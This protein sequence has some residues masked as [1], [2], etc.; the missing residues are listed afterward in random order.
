MRSNTNILPLAAAALLAPLAALAD[1][2][3]V[4]DA[5]VREGPPSVRVLAGY[6]QVHNRTDAPVA[7]TGASSPAVDRIELHR[8][9]MREGVA[10]MIEQER[11]EI[12]A[13]AS[14]AFEPGGLH[15]MLFDPPEPL[16]AGDSVQI[17]LALE[18]AET[19]SV[20]AQVRKMT[21]AD[22]GHDHHHHH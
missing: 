1:P 8:T 12:P 3:E 13:G 10:R 5:W 22:M 18:G 20:E 14:V 7:I 19:V 4:Q 15:L 9:E 16:R 6:M 17:E 2:V 11:V 21:G